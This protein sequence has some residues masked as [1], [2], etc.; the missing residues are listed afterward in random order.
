MSVCMYERNLFVSLVSPSGVGEDLVIEGG[1]GGG[2]ECHFI[3]TICLLLNFYKSIFYLLVTHVI[4]GF[5]CIHTLRF[6]LKVFYFN[7]CS[8]LN[9]DEL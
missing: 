7:T 5:L 6:E 8:E 9:G 1:G 4:E 3:F 2:G